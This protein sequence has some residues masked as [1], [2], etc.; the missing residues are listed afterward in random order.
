MYTW[1]KYVGGLSEATERIFRKYRMSITSSKYCKPRNNDIFLFPSLPFIFCYGARNSRVSCSL[2]QSFVPRFAASRKYT[3]FATID[4]TI[5]IR[6]KFYGIS[7]FIPSPSDGVGE[8]IMYLCFRLFR[9]SVRSFVW[10][11]IVTTISHE[12]FE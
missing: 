6:C 9:S 12:R 3:R 2:T 5:S 4:W 11:D 8:C 7:V 1:P 10:S